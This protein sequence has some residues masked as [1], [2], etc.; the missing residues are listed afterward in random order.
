MGLRILS[1]PLHILIFIGGWLSF[2]LGAI[3]VVLPILPTT[4]FML[5]AAACFARTS[6]KFHEWL[7]NSR[8]FGKLIRDWQ[9]GRFIEASAKKRALIVVALTFS[10]SI[11]V[12]DF[13]WLRVMLVG[14]WLT[15][16][17]FIGRLP[18]QPQS[19]S[20]KVVSNK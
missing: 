14:F 2:A 15:C 13:F 16:T 17:F 1:R 19:D 3:G 6:P 9:S 11:W 20:V 18:T 4:P 7:L 10:F 8:V 12:V 5:L